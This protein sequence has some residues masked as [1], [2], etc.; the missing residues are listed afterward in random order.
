MATGENM[1]LKRKANEF[2]I[3]RLA[4]SVD[5]DCTATEI[6]E[7]L[8]LTPDTVRRI[9]KLRGWDLQEGSRSSTEGYHAVDRMIKT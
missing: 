2:R 3:W 7:E 6:A 9:C 5:W 4:S 8:N 1:V